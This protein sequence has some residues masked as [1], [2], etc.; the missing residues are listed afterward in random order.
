MLGLL[1]EQGGN[2]ITT[3]TTTHLEGL[4]VTGR[5]ERHHDTRGVLIAL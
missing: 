1:T 3:R 5:L 2:L 4:K